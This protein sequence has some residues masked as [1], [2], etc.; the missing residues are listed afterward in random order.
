MLYRRIYEK[1]VEKAF[2]IVY[3][4]L[5]EMRI[6]FLERT[7]NRAAPTVGTVCK[8][9][10]NRRCVKGTASFPII[11]NAESFVTTQQSEF[12]PSR[13]IC[14]RTLFAKMIL[15]SECIAG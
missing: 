9:M 15:N 11:L 6:C 14:R 3:I 5:K 8:S 12:L 2:E 1:D 4:I 13:N 7:S 10:K